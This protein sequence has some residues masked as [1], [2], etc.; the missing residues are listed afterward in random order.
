MYGIIGEQGVSSMSGKHLLEVKDIRVVFP[1]KKGEFAAV[2][3]VTF[4]LDQGEILCIVGESGSGKTMTGLS[5][6]GL[7]PEQARVAAG[8]VR[9]QGRELLGLSEQEM[10]GI[11]GKEISMIFQDPMV[12]LDQVFTVG[13]Q[14]VEAIR[15]HTKMDKRS[16]V[17]L[18]LEMLD[19]VRI[20]NPERV[21]GS[22]PFELSGGMCQR[23]MIAIALCCHPKVLIADEPTTALDATVQAQI[24]ELLVELRDATHI[25]IILIT[26][27]LDI[28]KGMADR[29]IVMYAGKMMEMGTR[30]DVFSNPL[31]PYTQ[32]LLKCVPTLDMP[33]GF[34][35]Y[36]LEGIVPDIQDMPE[37]CR[38][39]TRCPRAEE[40]CCIVQ[41]ELREI[42]PGHFVS[43][44]KV[45]EVSEVKA[46]WAQ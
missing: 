42:A 5:V 30:Q 38:F 35:L 25:G 21:F 24:L 14:L 41:P 11:R 6:L 1:G 20:P 17:E 10:Y 16:A 43:C 13:S 18:S 19:K 44:L 36:N 26:H 8:T 31:H 22:Y 9:Y 3:G 4:H 32:G 2:D 33:E 39:C 23:V 7:L 27:D 29:I 28:V 40:E 34:R 12:S 37:G 15:V 45:D 46:G